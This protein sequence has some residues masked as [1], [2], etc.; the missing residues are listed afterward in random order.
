MFSQNFI[1]KNKIL[2][3][4]QSNYKAQKPIL[5]KRRRDRINSSLDELKNLLLAIKQRD[6]SSQSTSEFVSEIFI[7]SITTIFEM[8]NLYQTSAA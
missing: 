7:H 5:E 4:L 6:V 8:K 2:F 1:Q 3:R